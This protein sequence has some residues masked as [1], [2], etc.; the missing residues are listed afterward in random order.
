MKNNIESTFRIKFL[1]NA[2]YKLGSIPSFISE[3]GSFLSSE[4]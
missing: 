2:F 1:Y 4:I 3:Q